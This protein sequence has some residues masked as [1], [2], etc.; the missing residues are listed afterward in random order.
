MKQG[1]IIYATIIAAP[2]FTKNKNLDRDPE[3]H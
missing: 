3:M 2:S 1:T